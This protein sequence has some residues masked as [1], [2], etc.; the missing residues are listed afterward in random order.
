MNMDFDC[1]TLVFMALTALMFTLVKLDQR[2]LPC[3]KMGET[4]LCAFPIFTLALITVAIG[5]VLLLFRAVGLAFAVLVR[6][7]LAL[8]EAGGERNIAED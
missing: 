8:L 6:T 2:H 3:N 4:Y 5:L 1:R 7:L